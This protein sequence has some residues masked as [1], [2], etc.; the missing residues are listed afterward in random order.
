M[1]PPTIVVISD[2]KIFMALLTAHLHSKGYIVRSFATSA[3]GIAECKQH[4]PDLALLNYATFADPPDSY[5][6]CT[7][8]RRQYPAL[9]LILVTPNHGEALRVGASAWFD[10]VFNIEHIATEIDALLHRSAS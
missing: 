8:L 6:A 3:T 2:D 1:L 10:V 9:P 7:D 5:T 4:P